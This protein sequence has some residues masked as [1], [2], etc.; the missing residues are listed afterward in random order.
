MRKRALTLT[1]V[2]V[3]ALA[4]YSLLVEP[5]RVTAT[6]VSVVSPKLSERLNGYRIVLVSD[7]HIRDVG[8]REEAAIG[9]V[10]AAKPNLVVVAGDLLDSKGGVKPAVEFIHRL[11][12]AA[13]T[14]AVWG[15]WD[16]WSGVDLQRFKLL[17]EEHS[18]VTVLVNDALKVYEGL[19]VV[20][21]DDPCTGY[22]DLD[23]ALRSVN[24]P[25]FTVL[26][27]HSPE[28]IGV[29]KGR[30]DLVLAGHTHGGQIVVPL[31]GPLLVPLPREYAKYAY[32][33]FNA[34]G[35]FMVVTRGLGT[36]I[37]PARFGC[38]PEVMV[39]VLQRC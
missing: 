27:A 33:L 22:A 1:L 29:A 23:K 14:V 12:S 4:L 6:T 31:T 10:K 21:V 30:V 8:F 7:L 39:V 36:S 37:V 32:G 2:A 20:G 9:I 17:L 15:N 28:I 25:G 38:P 35:T 13:T 34:T 26:V 18:N 24:E 16:H 11:A 5:N 19:T 3:L